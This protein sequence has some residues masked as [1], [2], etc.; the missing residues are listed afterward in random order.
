MAKVYPF[1]AYRYDS[2]E[3]GDLSK[4]VS[5]PYDKIDSSERERYARLSPY[6]IVR[7]ILSEPDEELGEYDN[8]ARQLERWIENGVLRRDP[9]PGIY[10]YFQQYSLEGQRYTRRGF[11][12]LG[13][14][15][16]EGSEDRVKAHEETMEGPKADRLN[17]LRTTEAN[18]GQIFM[19]YSDPQ[20]R[21][22]EILEESAA[23]EPLIRAKDRVKD[24]GQVTHKIWKIDEAEKV[25]EI[26]QIMEGKSLYIADG[27]H[28]YETALNFRDECRARGWSSPGPE[29]FNCR[30][31]TFVNLEDPGLVILPT[32]RLLYG[33]KGFRARGV[34]EEARG[35]FSISRYS[36]REGLYRRLD[37]DGGERHTFGYRARG[38]QA[39]WALTLKDE[40]TMDQLIP[41][42]S[43]AWRRLDVS[44]LHKGILERYLD[45][46]EEDLQAEENVDYVRGR[47]EALDSLGGSKYQAAFILNPTRVEQVK[48]IADKGERM[49]QK[50]TDFYPKLLTGLVVHKLE[51]DK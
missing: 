9:E 28:R 17:L 43:P 48:E 16:G 14:L 25:E 6:N 27:H 22:A 32:H 11:I 1:S 36:D 8:A 46:D 10:P 13:E 5:Q 41:E 30:M 49:P 31:M 42:R 23:D 21:V 18:F 45:I 3:V 47:D 15:E 34:L 35:E 50:S 38:G 40:E 19:L 33:L 51:I 29:G 44:I 20:L 12:A 2:A 37:E 7:I 26:R 4:V 24:E 39:Y